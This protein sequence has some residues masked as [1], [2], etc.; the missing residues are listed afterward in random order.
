M[1]GFG[2]LEGTY[3]EL[4]KNLRVLGPY[5]E[6]RLRLTFFCHSTSGEYRHLG[7]YSENRLRLGLRLR[8][9]HR[10]RLSAKKAN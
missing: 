10:L 8:L 2:G 1:E 7:P 3:L 9:G 4:G 5:L 6:N